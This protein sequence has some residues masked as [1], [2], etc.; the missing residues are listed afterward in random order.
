MLGCNGCHRGP[1]PKVK[2]A[3]AI[4][5]SLLTN[6]SLT[7]LRLI[8]QRCGTEGV[9]ALSE[10][11]CHNVT[12]KLLDISYNGHV[13]SKA[14]IA[15]GLMLSKNRTLTDLNMRQTQVYV[16]YSVGYR[17]RVTREQSFAQAQHG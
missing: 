11:L 13:G 7:H 9:I 17:N 15:V 1:Y 6:S 2:G 5:T 4:A 12:L 3:R 16:A 8:G 10:A 14:G